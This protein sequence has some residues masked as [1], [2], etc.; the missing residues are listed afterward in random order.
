M[1]LWYLCVV[2]MLMPAGSASGGEHFACNLGA[3]T[4]DERTQHAKVSKKLLDS[5]QETKELKN[6]YAFRMPAGSLLTAAQWIAFER[7]CCPFF[8]FELEQSRDS[9]PVWLSVTGTTGVKE[10]IKEELG[11]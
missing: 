11:L 5:V 4:K 9:G 7:R 8:A 3:L 10:F 1:K 6:G 2:V